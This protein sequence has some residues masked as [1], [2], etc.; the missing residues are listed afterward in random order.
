MSGPREQHSSPDSTS[1]SSRRKVEKEKP[2]ER[3]AEE[4]MYVIA[5]QDADTDSERRGTEGN[6]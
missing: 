4:E 5:D 2:Q 6:H 1:P 3:H